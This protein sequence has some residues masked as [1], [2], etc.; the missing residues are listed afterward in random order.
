MYDGDSH[1]VDYKITATKTPWGTF[2]LSGLIEI[3]DAL[4]QG[5]DITAVADSIVFNADPASTLFHPDWCALM[6]TTPRM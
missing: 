6:S 2:N 3:R 1:D 5:F 4:D